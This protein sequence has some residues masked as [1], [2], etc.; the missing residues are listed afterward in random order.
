MKGR[1]VK[2]VVKVNTEHC[3]P[4]D[5]MNIHIAW[6]CE[7]LDGLELISREVSSRKL[8]FKFGLS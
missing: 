5:I 2:E 4:N 6:R 1:K 7:I 8:Q 3:P